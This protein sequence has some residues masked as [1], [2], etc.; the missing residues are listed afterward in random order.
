MEIMFLFKKSLLLFKDKIDLFT[1][2]IW[3]FQQLIAF[4]WEQIHQKKIIPTLLTAELQLQNLG[5]TEKL[6]QVKRYS[7]ILSDLTHF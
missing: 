2:P 3:Y 1:Q 5:I 7:L 6:G 4:S